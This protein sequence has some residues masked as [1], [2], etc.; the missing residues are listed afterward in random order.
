LF[1][2]LV[3]QAVSVAPLT[4]SDLRHGRNISQPQDIVYT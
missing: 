2:R 4:K 3:Q 1:F